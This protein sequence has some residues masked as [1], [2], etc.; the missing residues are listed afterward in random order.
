METII[1]LIPNDDDVALVRQELK[2]AGFAKNKINIL[3]QPADVWQR[4]EGRQEI[5]IVF[6]DAVIGMLIGLLVGAIYGVPAGISNCRFMNCSLE[7]SVIL[8]LIISLFWV[9]AGGFLGAIL[10]F[11]KFEADFYSYVEGVERGEALFVVE[12]SEDQAPEA[13]RILQQENGIL[14]H[15]IHDETGA[16]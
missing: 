12:S 10:G 7:T 14:I 2:K 1:G 11:D 9:V 4:L 8:W 15:E 3:F 6:K 13:M 16:R 5:R